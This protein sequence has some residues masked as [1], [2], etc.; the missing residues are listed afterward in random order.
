[1]NTHI[2]GCCALRVPPWRPLVRPAAHPILPEDLR[3]DLQWA[4]AM[5][6]R[7]DADRDCHG[8]LSCM[9]GAAEATQGRRMVG[10]V[11]FPSQSPGVAVADIPVSKGKI[12][13]ELS[14][15]VA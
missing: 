12:G 4:V 15:A 1:M 9:L 14:S 8:G 5:L 3:R 6:V 7:D 11:P 13:S 10:Q 2:S